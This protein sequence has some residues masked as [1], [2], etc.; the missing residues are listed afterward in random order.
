MKRPRWRP[1]YGIWLVEAGA[2]VV[3]IS[4]IFVLTA[5]ALDRWTLS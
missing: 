2:L 5:I 4:L 1:Y 3:V